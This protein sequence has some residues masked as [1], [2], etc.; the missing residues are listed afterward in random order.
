MSEKTPVL[1]LGSGAMALLFGAYLGAAGYPVTLLGSWREGIEA[2]RERGIRLW[3]QDVCREIP[4]QAVTEPEAVGKIRL[5]LVLVKS[6]QTERAARTLSACLHPQGLAVTL[7]NGLGNRETLERVLG[8]ARVVQG[9][10]TYGATLLGAGEVR[11]GGTGKIF[12]PRDQRLAPLRQA[13]QAAGLEMEESDE[14]EGIIWGKLVINSAIN[15]LTALL[16]IP[17][18]ELLRR[19]TARAL[20]GAIADETASVARAKGIVLPFRDVRAMVEEVAGR[21]GENLSSMLQDVRR[22]APTEIDAICGAIYRQARALGLDAALNWCMWQAVQA[23]NRSPQ[24][25]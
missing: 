13:L 18:G 23:L 6:W 17:N 14:L 3:S 2:V 24:A 16:N 21:T 8:K 1:I 4:V 12:L 9:V 15:P 10:T 11:L 7:Q 25:E 5:A 20:M 19:P 22:G